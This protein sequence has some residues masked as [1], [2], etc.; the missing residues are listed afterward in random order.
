MPWKIC[1]LDAYIQS[2]MSNANKCQQ[3]YKKIV[4]A[5]VRLYLIFDCTD[6]MLQRLSPSFPAL[7]TM[8]ITDIDTAACTHTHALTGC[9]LRTASVHMTFYANSTLLSRLTS[10][11]LQ[12]LKT[13]KCVAKP[14]V[15]SPGHNQ[16]MNA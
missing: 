5:I 15:S 13:R 2:F 14:S 3:T 7:F 1:T 9:Y 8:E 6:A 12:Q 4:T 11:N 10:V 16:N